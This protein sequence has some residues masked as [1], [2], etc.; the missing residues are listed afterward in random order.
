MPTLNLT[1]DQ[2]TDLVRQLPPAQQRRV[3][4]ALLTEQWPAWANL[5]RAGEE[6]I[7]AVAAQHGRDWTRM[8]EDEREAFVDD[9]LHE[10]RR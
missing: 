2:V 1:D 5:S 8:S 9:L 6:R 7:R 3:L 10:D 4:Q